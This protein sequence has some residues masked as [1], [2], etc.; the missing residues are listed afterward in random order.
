MVK[1]E[2]IY[3]SFGDREI[4][5]GID[6]TV[7]DGEFVCIMGES[8]SGKSTLLGIMGGNITPDGGRVFINGTDICR[9]K[10]AEMAKLRRMELGFVYQSLNLINTLRGD[11]NILLPLYL[12]KANIKK[13]RER[14]GELA[15]IMG[16]SHVLKSFPEQMSGGER[17]RI[18]IAR[19]LIHSPSVIMLDEPTGS[20]DSESTAHVLELLKKINREMNVSIIQVTH[21]EDAASYGNRTVYLRDGRVT[22]G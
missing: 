9:L 20:L 6:I 15:D 17:Q 10:E 16:I 7:E 13:G 4:L 11:E 18:A 3:K 8:G 14:M 5:H 2:K 1:A 21:S 22:E 12:D 19:A